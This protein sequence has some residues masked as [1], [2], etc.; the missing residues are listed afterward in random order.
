MVIGNWVGVGKIYMCSVQMD[1]VHFYL[2]E[3]GFCGF[4]VY[5]N[6]LIVDVSIVNLGGTCMHL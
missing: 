6:L 2:I 5:V 4:W 3:M 1:S